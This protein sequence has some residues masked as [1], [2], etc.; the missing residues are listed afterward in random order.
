MKFNILYV[1][2]AWTYDDKA[3]AGNRGAS[4]KYELMTEDDIAR[5][6]VRSIAADDCVL[7]LWATFPKMREALDVIEAWG[8]TY[9]TCAFTWVKPSGPFARL[10]EYLDSGGWTD[11]RLFELLRAVKTRWFIGMGRWSRSNAEVC[12]LATRGKPQR[13]DAGVNQIICAPRLLHSAKPPETRD[14]IVR[15]CGDVPRVE[16]FA[17]ERVPGWVCL[18]YDAD[19]RDLRESIPALSKLPTRTVQ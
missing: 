16:L 3:L 15:L 1:D 13:L 11:V 5:L 6:P 17:R 19:G 18:G 2:P 8:F 10:L 7:F 12:L 14:R 4:C 9:K